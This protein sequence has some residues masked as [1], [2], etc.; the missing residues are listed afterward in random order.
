MKSY[1]SHNLKE[2]MEITLNSY[3]LFSKEILSD[4]PAIHHQKNAEAKIFR[5]QKRG[6]KSSPFPNN[7][8]HR[9]NTNDDYL[10][11]SPFI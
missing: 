8:C 4:S 7:A 10:V 5:D 6:S 11:N 3:K 1:I 9:N 2:V